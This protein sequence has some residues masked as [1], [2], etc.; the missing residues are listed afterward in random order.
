[1]ALPPKNA[2]SKEEQPI[3]AGLTTDEVAARRQA[4]QGN[5]AKVQSSRTYAQILRENVFSFI[6]GVFFL[7]AIVLISLGRWEDAVTVG[8]M[9]AGGSSVNLIQELRAKRQLDQIALLTRPAVSVI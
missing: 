3:L 1:M 9:I 8:L 7:I 5:N 2:A 6:N 4:G